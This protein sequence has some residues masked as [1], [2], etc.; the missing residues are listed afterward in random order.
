MMK[1]FQNKI[2]AIEYYIPN[3][4]GRLFS[5][6]INKEEIIVYSIQCF[7][8]VQNS[9]IVLQWEFYDCSYDSS[10]NEIFPLRRI[11]LVIHLYFILNCAHYIN[12]LKFMIS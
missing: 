6:I 2:F 3:I 5:H 8:I 11:Q 1:F 12:I 9:S 10:S 7:A 4:S